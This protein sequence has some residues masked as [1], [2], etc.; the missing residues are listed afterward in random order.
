MPNDGRTPQSVS[1]SSETAP[2]PSVSLTGRTYPKQASPVDLS[3]WQALLKEAES[4]QRQL[5]SGWSEQGGATHRRYWRLYCKVLGE[6]A[7]TMAS[8]ST[9]R[10]TRAAYRYG[11][12]RCFVSIERFDELALLKAFKELQ[13]FE[14]EVLQAES[15]RTQETQDSGFHTLAAFLRTRGFSVSGPPDG[16]FP[17]RKGRV[18]RL[19]ALSAGWRDTLLAA[20]RTEIPQMPQALA[21]MALLGCRPCEVA[22]AHIGMTADRKLELT[23]ESDKSLG[24]AEVRTRGAIFEIDAISSILVDLAQPSGTRLATPF[25]HITPKQIENVLRRASQRAFPKLSPPVSA[26]AFRNQVASDLK[27]A[28]VG[29][30]ELAHLLGHI[31]DDQQKTYGR[32][33]Y[34]SGSKGWLPIAILRSHAVRLD[35]A[36]RYPRESSDDWDRDDDS[37]KSDSPW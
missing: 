10:I 7:I 28:G 35:R 16:I 34:G 15:R 3:S 33:R 21:L 9:V 20:V 31:S 32:A 18:Q 25:S 8:R 4:A 12:Q 23:V 6:K 29:A 14:R 26:Y 13:A 11:L 1:S 36:S 37:V 17:K 22:S 30:E 5:R 19:R 24:Q 2:V 27:Q